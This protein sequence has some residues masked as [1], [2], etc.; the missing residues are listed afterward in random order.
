MRRKILCVTLGL[1]LA[2]LMS[3]STIGR[4]RATVMTEN[5][6]GATYKGTDAFYGAS[7]TAF[8]VGSQATVI[9]PFYNN[10]GSAVSVS[11]VKI[12][13][14][15]GG[16]YSSGEIPSGMTIIVEAG[17]TKTFT[18]NFTVPGT[19]TASNLF[20]HS[21]IISVV[22]NRTTETTSGY[23]FAVYS[24][25]QV[26]ARDLKTTI[27]GYGLTSGYFHYA[28]SKMLWL[29]SENETSAGDRAYGLGDFSGAKAHY[30]TALSLINQALSAEQSMGTR[31]DDAQLKNAES[32]A[33]FLNAGPF[34]FGIAAIVFSAGYV[35]KGIAAL[36]RPRTE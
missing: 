28:E 13:F 10:W 18:I 8:E 9:I 17:K 33:N 35:I 12:V 31:L 14:D 32:T 25:D 1:A 34:Y 7:V 21:Y 29:K 30:T 26:D 6:I 4:A 22:H 24:A 15:W 20:A 3:M 11:E 23:N 19:S 16:S 27:S 2:T 36:R 5:W